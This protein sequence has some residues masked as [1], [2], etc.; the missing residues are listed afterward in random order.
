DPFVHRLETDVDLDRRSRLDGDQTLAPLLGRVDVE[1]VFTHLPRLAHDVA[2]REDERTVHVLAG[3]VLQLSR[4]PVSRK[5][6]T[7]PGTNGDTSPPSAATW[8]TRE[9]DTIACAGSG[10]RKTVSTCARCRFTIAMGVSYATS[11][12]DRIPLT[13]TPALTSV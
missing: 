12:C 7:G 10:R 2:H 8:R 9:L 1:L 11:T 3:H 4:N 13:S 6:A 5:R